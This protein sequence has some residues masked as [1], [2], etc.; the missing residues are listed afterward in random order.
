MVRSAWKD[1]TVQDEFAAWTGRLNRWGVEITPTEFEDRL[2]HAAEAYTTVWENARRPFKRYYEYCGTIQSW[3][4]IAGPH[5]Y[6]T[7]LEI[8]VERDGRWQAVYIQRDAAQ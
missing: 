6:P 4:M 5:R 7:R 1:P 2:W 3:R 8:D